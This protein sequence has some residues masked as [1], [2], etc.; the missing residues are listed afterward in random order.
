M[1]SIART[2]GIALSLLL[3]A[4][5]A[6]SQTPPQRLPPA[7]NFAPA[8]PPN[9]VVE[10]A[11]TLGVVKCLPAITRLS[12]V[13]IAGSRTHDVLVDWDRAKPDG[14]PFFSLVGVSFGQ[15]S[16]AA[17]ITAVPQGDNGCTIA[18]ERISVAPYTCQSIAQVELNGYTA[19]QLLPTFTVY[20]QAQDPGASVTL[21]DNPPSC[22]VIRRHV[23]YGWT[24][25][26]AR[27]PAR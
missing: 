6:T 11:R 16:L 22:L 9:L 13:A 20:T 3:F 21:I 26:A 10:A 17:T 1:R 19:T 5:I 12:T 23:Q 8:T 4:G 18:A 25:P 15:Q 7:P 14:G 27:P 24:D 2:L